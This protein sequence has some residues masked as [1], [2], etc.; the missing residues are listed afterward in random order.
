MS[1]EHENHGKSVANWTG[2]AVILVGS[3]LMSIA[4]IVASTP[5]FIV[6]VVVAIGGIVAGKVLSMAGYGVDATRKR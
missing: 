1:E 2:V 6:G 5:L 3:L 4:V